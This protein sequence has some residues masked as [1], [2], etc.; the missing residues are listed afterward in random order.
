MWVTV[1][2]KREICIVADRV[3]PVSSGDGATSYRIKTSDC[4][5]RGQCDPSAD[6]CQL[7]YR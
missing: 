4:L 3:P 1:C 7:L 2:N 6:I 5:G